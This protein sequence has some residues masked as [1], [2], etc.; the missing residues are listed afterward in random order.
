[1]KLCFVP[2]LGYTGNETPVEYNCEMKRGIVYTCIMFL[3]QCPDI[4]R[5]VVVCDEDGLFLLEALLLS[6]S[7]L[8]YKTMFSFL[9][10]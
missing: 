10:R 4:L 1:M 9:T 8:C 2:D 3:H 5:G 7:S 6:A